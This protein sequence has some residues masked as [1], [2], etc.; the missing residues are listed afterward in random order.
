M[1]QLDQPDS[2][3]TVNFA[4]YVVDVHGDTV[5]HFEPTLLEGV[6]VLSHPGRVSKT[7]TDHPLYFSASTPQG[8]ATATTIKLIPYYAWAN[9]APAQMQVWIPYREA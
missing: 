3:A 4:D 6:M 9:R 8:P 7:A 5:E 2:S 1:E